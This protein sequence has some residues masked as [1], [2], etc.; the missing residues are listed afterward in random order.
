MSV[1]HCLSG[2]EPAAH[3]SEAEELRP[4]EGDRG[5]QSDRTFVREMAFLTVPEFKCIPQ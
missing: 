4:S 3:S 1:K 2:G 5:K